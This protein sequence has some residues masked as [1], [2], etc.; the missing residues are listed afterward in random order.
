MEKE[1]TFRI[2]PTDEQKK[3]FEKN[4]YCSRFIYE[5]FLPK[6]QEDE[7]K[8][9]LE[10][11]EEYLNPWVYDKKITKLKQQEGYEF[12]QE[13]GI[14]ALQGAMKKLFAKVH[15]SRKQKKIKYPP[16]QLAKNKKNSFLV[17]QN[18]NGIGIYLCSHGL[19]IPKIEYIQINQTQFVPNQWKMKEVEIYE[20][21]QG[22]YYAHLNYND[23]S[24]NKSLTE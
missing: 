17:L 19:K 2:F 1:F 23:F 22:L 24:Q 15:V 21:P 8:N 9:H 14:T 6:I 20:T 16:Y 13:V 3:F 4:F 5:Y 12:L 11:G 18:T 7:E 10:F